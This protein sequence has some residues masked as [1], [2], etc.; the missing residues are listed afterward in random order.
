MP[1]TITIPFIECEPTPAQGYKLTWRVVGSGDPYTDEG[2]VTSSPAIFTDPDG[3]EGDCYEGFLQ[4]DCSESGESG[5][6]LG[7]AIPWAT[8]CEES[9]FD[10]SSCGTIISQTTASLD[11]VNLGF[12]DL[13]VSGSTTVDLSY[14]VLGRPNKITLY[15]DGVIIDTTGWKGTA[16]YGGPWGMSLSTIST[17][18]MAF[19]PIL[20]SAYKLLIEVGPAGPAPYDVSDNFTINVECTSE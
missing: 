20:G 18:T 12:F 15:E 6:V 1:N 14:D 13:F 19:T 16:P 3:L 10:N 2:Y 11:Y 4:S 5:T 9:G 7:E 17:G 8:P